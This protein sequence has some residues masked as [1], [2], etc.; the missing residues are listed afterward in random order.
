MMQL[1]APL[2]RSERDGLEMDIVL[3]H[4]IHQ[5]SELLADEV[6]TKHAAKPDI[7]NITGTVDKAFGNICPS[8][9]ISLR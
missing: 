9:W 8:S 4:Q 2:A 5:L 6:T 3:I 7:V 1:S